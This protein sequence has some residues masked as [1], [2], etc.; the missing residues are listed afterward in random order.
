[1]EERFRDEMAVRDKYQ[2]PHFEKMQEAIFSIILSV[3]KL[4]S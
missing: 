2:K 4:G 3:P 1:M